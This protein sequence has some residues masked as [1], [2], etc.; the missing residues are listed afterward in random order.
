MNTLGWGYAARNATNCHST[1]QGHRQRPCSPHARDWSDVTMRLEGGR[2][3]RPAIVFRLQNSSRTRA[4]THNSSPYSSHLP[5][6]IRQRHPRW[7]ASKPP[8]VC[9]RTRQS[10][11]T[12]NSSSFPTGWLV[13]LHAR[14]RH[15]TSATSP[16]CPPDVASLPLDRSLN[17][18]YRD[19]TITTRDS[20]DCA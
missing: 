20:N 5:L 13:R 19:G 15:D 12:R 2:V 9:S 14:V 17:G 6:L 7:P 4:H 10:T 11:R 1:A 16:R 18:V 3:C 8:R